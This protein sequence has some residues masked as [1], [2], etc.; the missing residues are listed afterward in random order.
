M[1]AL[2]SGHINNVSVV[3]FFP[4]DIQGTQ[5]ILSGSVDQTIRI[6]RSNVES[7]VG[8]TSE[9]TLHGHTG[10]INSLAVLAQSHVVASGASD[11]TIKIWSLH[12]TENRVH[13]DLL[14]TIRI[15]PRFFPLTLALDCLGQTGALVLAVAGTK[16]IIQLYVNGQDQNLSTF[17]LQATLT[18]HEGW[19]RS[20]DF[21]HEHK[22]GGDD[23]ILASASQDKYIR[24][25]RVRQAQD[26][27]L[28]IH[29]AAGT[30]VKAL[31]NKAHRLKILN[32]SYSVTFEAL[33]LAHEDWVYTASWKQNGDHLQLLSASA[34]NSLAIW[35]SDLSSGV[36]VCATRLG[37]ISAQKGSTTATG[38]TGGFWIGLWSP[39]GTSVASLGRT[40]SWRLWN[41][42]RENDRWVQGLGISG[43]VKNVKGIAWAKDGTYLLS[44]SS[45]QTTRL[46][47]E[48]KRGTSRSWHE[49]ARPQIHGYDLNCI[50][51]FGQSQF[52]SGADEK[53]LRVFDEPRAI[54]EMLEKLCGI[55]NV[56]YEEMAV[57][58]NMPVLGLSNKAVETMDD[59]LD[60]NEEIENDDTDAPDPASVVR[61]AN[62][63]CDRPPVEDQL[64]R[65]T[66]WPEREKLYGHGY[67]ISVVAANHSGSMIAT[68]CKATS[69][70][71]AVIRLY[72]TQHWREIKPS[73]TAHTL[74]VTC[75]RFSD[76]DEYLLS[77]GR[78]RQWA[79]FERRSDGED[80]YGLK[81]SNPKSHSR[82]ILGAAWA[83]LFTRGTFATAG[84]DKC[85][86]VWKLLN[87]GFRCGNPILA[88]SSVTSV[89]FLPAG[90][91]DLLWL[92]VGTET[93]AV[94]LFR[95]DPI[96]LETQALHAVDQR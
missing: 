58:A 17:T 62:F 63:N 35:E 88:S 43:H 45:D 4:S 64:A 68:A 78:D 84:R 32:T 65:H 30:S 80:T 9:A 83:P 38:S 13:S 40:G 55:R 53:L 77:V 3:R 59:D 72:E 69:I 82:M 54:A 12:I 5:V 42:D 7:P 49:F 89:D 20:L 76:D 23:L 22:D 27:S 48:W 39:D 21:A 33:L 61:K 34:D 19:I 51:S 25:W 95:L 2:L 36:W 52:I 74:T 92:A 66:L 79:V 16:D 24:L 60:A 75:L 28:A 85:V 44:T 15:Q 26:I 94:F 41:H 70:E 90:L 11:A 6:W 73:L 50:D 87:E 29:S 71:H 37:E 86:K 47:S 1:Q 31:S 67:E 14:Q 96:T 91:V 56:C 46:H 10:S 57:A 81:A 93:G 8:F 18:G